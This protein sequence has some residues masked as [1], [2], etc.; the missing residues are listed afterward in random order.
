MKIECVPLLR[1]N[2]REFLVETFRQLRQKSSSSHEQYPLAEISSQIYVYPLQNLRDVFRERREILSNESR[3][4]ENFCAL[5]AL[6]DDVESV[7]C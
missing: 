2:E 4:E 3:V 6:R 5:E 7:V 1:E